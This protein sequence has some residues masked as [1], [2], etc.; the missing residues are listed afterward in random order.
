MVYIDNN[1]LKSNFD[2]ICVCDNKNKSNG[3][4]FFRCLCFVVMNEI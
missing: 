3:C 4:I 2:I 1:F